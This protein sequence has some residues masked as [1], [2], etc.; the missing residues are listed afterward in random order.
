M[1]AFAL[2]GAQRRQQS[3]GERSFLEPL[4][5]QQAI[6]DRF[7]LGGQV[8]HDAVPP[9]VDPVEDAQPGHLDDLPLS[10]LLRGAPPP[11][12]AEQGEHLPRR[13]IDD[14]ELAVDLDRAAALE[15]ALHVPGAEHPAVAA[16]LRPDLEPVDTLLAPR[17]EAELPERAA[18]GQ[19]ALVQ[20]DSR[21]VERLEQQREP[22][23]ECPGRHRHQVGCG[24]LTEDLPAENGEGDPV[25]LEF[26]AQFDGGD[27]P[28]PAVEGQR[29]G[30]LP[31]RDEVGLQQ[32]PH[33]VA[34]VV[35]VD[36]RVPRRPRDGPLR[37]LVR[38]RGEHL[39]EG[40]AEHRPALV[41]AQRLRDADP[42]ELEKPRDRRMRRHRALPEENLGAELPLIR[43]AAGEDAQ[44]IARLHCH[45]G[46]GLSGDFEHQGRRRLALVRRVV[47]RDPAQE[48]G[49]HRL[50]EFLLLVI[51]RVVVAGEDM[52]VVRERV[53]ERAGELVPDPPT[54]TVDHHRDGAGLEIECEAVAD[55][56]AAEFLSPEQKDF[57]GADALGPGVEFGAGGI[58]RCGEIAQRPVSRGGLQQQRVLAAVVRK[59]LDE[60]AQLAVEIEAQIRREQSA[61]LR[62]A[63]REVA[64][65]LRPLT[66]AHEIDVGDRP[67]GYDRD[68]EIAVG[69]DGAQH[70]ARWKATTSS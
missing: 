19:A 59:V 66:V 17:V 37:F 28:A 68:R 23:L 30:V 52:I 61:Q 54:P 38:R 22:G 31:C 29:A 5:V 4:E 36:V 44:P 7:V 48:L 20:L 27:D 47:G 51:L 1:P 26:P 32:V 63:G 65:L 33:F 16:D 45:R 55:L 35:P 64:V 53:R 70:W 56:R 6:D 24:H 39:D 8:N 43:V 25:E 69:D 62:R 42:R 10:A 41:G 15:N 67:P 46:N 9:Q 12:A 2:I 13:G 21:R 34:Q 57:R 11:H 50:G 40:R 58:V 14:P 18:H 49:Q 60:Q 3:G